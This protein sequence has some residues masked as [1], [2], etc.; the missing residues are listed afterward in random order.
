MGVGRILSRGASVGDFQVGPN[1][2]PPSDAHDLAFIGQS[3]RLRSETTPTEL[4]LGFKS[5][6]AKVQ[7]FQTKFAPEGETETFINV[8]HV[9]W[10]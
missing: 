10:N 3:S 9:D 6:D 7:L 4:N 8:P 5:N 2:T 1:A